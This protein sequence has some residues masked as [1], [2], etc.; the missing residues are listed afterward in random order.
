MR[1]HSLLVVVMLSPIGVTAQPRSPVL[2]SQTDYFHYICTSLTDQSRPLAE[3]NVRRKMYIARYQLDA[4]EVQAF[5]AAIQAFRESRQT[6]RVHGDTALAAARMHGGTLDD[7]SLGRALEAH[8]ARVLDISNVF[9]RAVRP[10][11]ALKLK[12]AVERQP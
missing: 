1:C 11:T 10:A 4:S 2:P 9:M 12:N 3:R 5:D 6:L 8:R 7:A